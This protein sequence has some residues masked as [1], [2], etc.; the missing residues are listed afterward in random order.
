M[1]FKRDPLDKY[2]AAFQPLPGAPAPLP[3][4]DLPRD[5]CKWP[6]AEQP[7]L[8]CGCA[9][10]TGRYCEEHERMSGVRLGPLA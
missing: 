10:D 1:L 2:A 5:G 3:L 7:T 6:V 4:I 9:S 8:F